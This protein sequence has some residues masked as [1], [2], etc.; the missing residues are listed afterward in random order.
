MPPRVSGADES[1]AVDVRHST[2]DG[3]ELVYRRIYARSGASVGVLTVTTLAADLSSS[4]AE[5]AVASRRGRFPIN[6][7]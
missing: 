2:K 1:I 5:P 3:R 6:G 7:Q 4:L